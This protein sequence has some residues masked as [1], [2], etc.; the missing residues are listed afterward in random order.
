MLA[1]AAEAE[2][3]DAYLMLIPVLV[4]HPSLSYGDG[5]GPVVASTRKCRRE[6]VQM[7]F[8]ASL[9]HVIAY[10]SGFSDRFGGPSLCVQAHNR[11]GLLSFE[12][13]FMVSSFMKVLF[14]F[15][16]TAMPTAFWVRA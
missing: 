1:Y 4:R 11:D 13:D 16:L 10:S 14:G 12:S 15:R 9:I 3:C 2:G 5:V 8:P 7:R 6:V